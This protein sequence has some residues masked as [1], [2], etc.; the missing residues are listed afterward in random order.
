M[1]RRL[2]AVVWLCWSV[3][4][5]GP[6]ASRLPEAAVRAVEAV[7][8]DDLRNYVGTLASDDFNGRG[9]GDRGN[10]AA[11][12]FICATLRG[13]SVTPAGA[14][15]S[16]YQ[17]VDVFKPA[18]GPAA[19]L[20]IT[21]EG[22]PA[23]ADLAAGADFYPLPQT[24]DAAVTAPLVFVEYG[25]SAPE[26]KY[27]DYARVDARGAIVLMREGFPEKFPNLDRLSEGGRADLGELPR[28]VEEARAHGARGVVLIGGYLSGF[29]TVW[30]EQVSI[31]DA[32]YRLVSSLREQ[33][34]PV[35]TL[36]RHA[37]DPIVRELEE[38]HRL[39]A[40]LNPDLI[41]S[42]VTIHNVLGIVEGRDDK[43]R[44]EMVV[45]G[46][47]LDHDGTDAAGRIYNGADDN[48]SGTAAVLAA[49]AAFARAAASGERPARSVLFALWNGEEKGELG[50]EAFVASPQPH[51]RVI[52]N[53]NLDMVG[54]HEEVPDPNDWRFHGLPKVD[55][56]GD[57]Q[58]AARAR[59]Q[60]HARHGGDGQGR[61]RGRRPAVA[62]RLRPGGAGPAP[63]IRPLAVP[64]PRDSRA[65]PDDRV[66][67]R[68]PHA[69]RRHRPD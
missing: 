39:T 9:V 45:L 22:E 57:R 36:S 42:T 32:S 54:R 17:P 65:L 31:R 52:A 48:A 55:A 66:T 61:Q 27:D 21:G 51:R 64:R 5:P 4:A 43:R 34:L 2:T 7:S 23:V 26:L 63:P 30:P 46:A 38:H 60:L 15:G 68:V 41:V 69:G 53:L 33:P 67:P 58:H 25:I 37:A 20:T 16:C 29:R 35:G 1:L 10:R 50:A 44:D 3:A 40:T 11:E 28:K 12:E 49:A 14:D 62:G 6:A 19:H 47:H 13:S 8:A 56:V 24:S 59:L 18:I